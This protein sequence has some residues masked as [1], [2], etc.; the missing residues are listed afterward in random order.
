MAGQWRR[1]PASGAIVTNLSP[2]NYTV[3]F[4]TIAGWPSPTNQTVTIS[5]GQTTTLGAS[6]IDATKPTLV[7]TSPAANQRWSNS[8]FTATGTAKDIH[9]CGVGLLPTQQRRLDDR[10]PRRPQPLDQIG[11]PL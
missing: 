6:Y 7:I 4:K 8:T 11:Q 5:A 2:T 10:H 9:R 1:F 3:S